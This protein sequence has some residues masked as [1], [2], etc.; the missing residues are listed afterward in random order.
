M[1]AL[2]DESLSSAN[3]D[4]LTGYGAAIGLAFQIYDDILDEEGE[5]EVLGK[6]P[7][8]DQARAKPTYPSVVGIDAA[9][10]R[11][12]LLHRSAIAALQGFSGNKTG[13]IW[14]SDYLLNR[15]H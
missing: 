5:L 2:A 14:L 11:V 6:R 15:N 9:H 10:T 8:Q 7:G 4:C 3:R 13:L 12:D 1:G